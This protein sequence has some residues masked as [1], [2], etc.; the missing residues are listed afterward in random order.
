MQYQI[1]MEISLLILLL[2]SPFFGSRFQITNPFGYLAFFI[3]LFFIAKFINHWAN[4]YNFLEGIHPDTILENIMFLIVYLFLAYI[5]ALVIN[6]YFRRSI[7]LIFT[8]YNSFH[9]FRPSSLSSFT[10]IFLQIS[11]VIIGLLQGINPIE[12]PLAFRQLIQGKGMFYLLSL[13]LFLTAVHCIYIPYKIITLKNKPPL[14]SIIAYISSFSFA[15][16]SGFASTIMI[17]I[18]SPLFF[19]NACYRKRVEILIFLGIPLAFGYTLIYSAYRDARISSSDISLLESI[20]KVASTPNLSEFAFNRFDYLEMF[21][22]GLSYSYDVES[23]YGLSLLSVVVQPIPRAFWTDKPENFSTSMT[24]ALLPQNYDIGVTA[25]FNSLNE[26][27]YSFGLIGVVVGGSFLGVLL[28]FSYQLFRN[29][30]CRPYLTV[31][32]LSVVFPYITTGFIAGY[33]NDLALPLAI[34]NFIYFILFVENL[35]K[36]DN[37][38]ER[39]QKSP[40]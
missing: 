16:I 17:F 5:F 10:V 8:K 21:S 29:S 27:I 14:I 24:R 3:G 35:N 31:F 23:D 39:L 9:D 36:N 4:D 33:I 32:Y 2:A 12:N 13:Q 34:L 19:Y 28:F 18:L 7:N 20:E 38:K 22:K 1:F 30:F 26:F 15:I 6:I 11:L 40:N 37:V 25:N